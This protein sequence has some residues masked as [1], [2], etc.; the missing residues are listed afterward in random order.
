MR[1]FDR[2]VDVVFLPQA[3]EYFE[4]L[5]EVVKQRMFRSFDKTSLGYR[6]PWFKYLDRGIWEFRA[7]DAQKFYRFLAFWDTR[8]EKR[9]LIVATSGFHKKTNR[10]PK[11]ELDRAIRIMKGYFEVEK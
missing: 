10:T 2:P 8:D 7:R 4:T 11:A 1:H 6:G 3:V 9:T 5:P